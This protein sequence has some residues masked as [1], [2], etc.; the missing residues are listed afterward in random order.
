MTAG[1]PA[2]LAAGRDRRG[3]DAHS[4][5]LIRPHAERGA[6]WLPRLGGVIHAGRTSDPPRAGDAAGARRASGPRAGRA[7]D[8]RHSV[9]P[10]FDLALG[11]T[12]LYLGVI[13]LIPLSAAFL[14]TFTM[15]WP[16]FLDAVASPRVLAAYRLTFGASFAAAL[17]NAAFG[18][19][20]TW[21]LVRYE[22]FGRR[23][24]DA[25]V[26]LPFALPTAV[27]G[28]A[29][30][31]L[32][33]EHGWI[34]RWLGARHQ[35]RVHAARRVRRAD[36]SGLPFVAYAAAGAR[37][38]LARRRGGRRRPARTATRPSRVIFRPVPALTG[39]ALAARALG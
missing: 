19:V 31:A 24:V 37:R 18:L 5:P 14:K 23:L 38:R 21:V 27:A 9:L 33:A 1:T 17:V 22:F 15:S 16:A 29:L 8:R 39:F 10:G 34:G 7:P 35:G 28:I 20:V 11:I 26:D 25:L 30:T 6:A 13:V 32:Y 36:P 3:D 4:T 12:L 2:A